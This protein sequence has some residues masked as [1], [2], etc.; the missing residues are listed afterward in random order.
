MHKCRFRHKH[1]SRR[2]GVGTVAWNI[3]PVNPVKMPTVHISSILRVDTVILQAVC[4]Y[5]IR[6][7]RTLVK[8][9]RLTRLIDVLF[10]N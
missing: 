5:Q 2:V 9:A 8:S 7:V 4:F 10:M 6:F 3:K 1:F